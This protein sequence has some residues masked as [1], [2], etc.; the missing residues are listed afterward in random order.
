MSSPEELLA[1]LYDRNEM[2]LHLPGELTTS[3]PQL[4]LESWKPQ[5]CLKSRCLA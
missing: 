4:T 5:C 1:E 3:A 2:A